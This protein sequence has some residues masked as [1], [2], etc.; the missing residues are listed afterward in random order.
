MSTEA[1][2]YFEIDFEI[3]DGLFQ[4]P[5]NPHSTTIK[6]HFGIASYFVG[7][8]KLQNKLF[9]SALKVNYAICVAQ[10]A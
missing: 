8:T 6:G 7:S 4:H 1:A 3:T 5:G 10:I 9:Q 2:H